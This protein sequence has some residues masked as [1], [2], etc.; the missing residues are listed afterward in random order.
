VLGFREEVGH[1]AGVD[2]RLAGDAGGQQFLA[3]RLEGAV[4]LGDEFQCLGG[5]NGGVFGGNGGVDLDAGGQG[6]KELL[7]MGCWDG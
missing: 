2:A 1:F 6:H 5:K 3:A 7:E 4:Q